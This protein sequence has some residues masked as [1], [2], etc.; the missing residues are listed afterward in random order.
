MSEKNDMKA[1]YDF[2]N[3]K[4][5]VRGKY[6]KAYRDG[7]MVTIHKEDSSTVNPVC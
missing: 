4:G 5:A 2:P 7:H 3:M 1:E 6:Y